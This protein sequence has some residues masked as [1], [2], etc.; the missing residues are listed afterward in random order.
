[1]SAKSPIWIVLLNCNTPAV[2]AECIRSLREMDSSHFE[3]L[4]IDNGSTDGSIE[5]LERE[6][7]GVS[8][9]SLKSNSGFAAGCNIGIRHAV[10]HDAEYVLLLNNDTT[11]APDFL[12]EALAALQADSSIGAVCPKI[13]FAE[14][15][16]MFWYAGADFSGWTAFTKHRGWRTLDRGQ[17]DVPEEIT[18]ATGCAM[19][20]RCSVLSDV[21]LLDEQFWAYA[22]DL[23]WSIRFRNKGYRLVF[24][25][26][27]RVW[28]HCGAT[29]KF[30]GSGSQAIRQFFST[31]NMLFVA[32]KHLHWYQ[33]PSFLLGFTLNHIF[34]YSL[35][36]L[37]E[38]DFRALFAI[39]RGLDQGLRSKLNVRSADGPIFSTQVPVTKEAIGH[40]D[41]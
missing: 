22:E 32:R 17:F 19:L 34:Y 5:F 27:A 11:V 3:I 1:M 9:L 4:V 15:P 7:P 18:Q 2:T 35:I 31:R 41:R 40:A 23:D 14:P 26:K 16:D 33:F 10:A 21:G 36:R 37:W 8:M 30:M 6:F 38:H 28:H 25:P 29:V 24:A 12:R 20:I 39:F 13:Y